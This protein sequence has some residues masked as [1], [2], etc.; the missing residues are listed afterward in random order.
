MSSEAD[1]FASYRL[2]GENVHLSSV[3]MEF[4]TNNQSVVYVLKTTN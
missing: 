2:T 3:L 1:G 4:Y